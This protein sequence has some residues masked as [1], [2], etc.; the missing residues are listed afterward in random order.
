MAQEREREHTVPP[1]STTINVLSRNERGSITRFES[2]TFNAFVR[3]NE[4]VIAHVPA[5][6]ISIAAHEVITDALGAAELVIT[7]EHSIGTTVG[8]RTRPPFTAKLHCAIDHAHVLSPIRVQN[9]AF[10]AP[11]VGRVR[12]DTAS[13][14]LIGPHQTVKGI[15]PL[16]PFTAIHAVRGTAL[17]CSEPAHP[18]RAGKL[19]ASSI[20]AVPIMLIRV[21]VA[22]AIL[23]ALSANIRVGPLRGDRIHDNPVRRFWKQTVGSK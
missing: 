16:S 20:A 19:T 12:R 8:V 9:R 10:I 4:R 15:R 17:F 5:R 13:V 23:V 1:L 7:L 14:R 6:G 3:S 11:R 2:M 21:R 22:T 18:S